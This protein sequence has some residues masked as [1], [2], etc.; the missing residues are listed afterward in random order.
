MLPYDTIRDSRH[1]HSITS[2]K[3]ERYYSAFL[4]KQAHASRVSSADDFQSTHPV[5]FRT[6]I[7]RDKVSLP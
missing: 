4:R 2:S 5:E 1:S 7:Q 3:R 6:F